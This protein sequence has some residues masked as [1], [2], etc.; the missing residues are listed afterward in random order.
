VK[1]RSKFS[2]PR[3]ESKSELKKKNRTYNRIPVSI[4]VR[5]WNRNLNILIL[6]IAQFFK[7]IHESPVIG[8]SP[9]RFWNFGHSPLQEGTTVRALYPPDSEIL[10]TPPCRKALLSGHYTLPCMRKNLSQKNYFECIRK[11]SL[12]EHNLLICKA[13]GVPDVKHPS[14]LPWVSAYFGN[15]LLLA[16]TF[17]GNVLGT[18]VPP[19]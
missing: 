1:T 8:P 6:P 5:N 13:A 14:A 16:Y 4:F 3:P 12:W 2:I 18:S 17:F 9:K 19:I 15:T 7:K 11:G 10:D